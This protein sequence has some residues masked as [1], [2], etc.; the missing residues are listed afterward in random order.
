MPVDTPVFAARKGTVVRKAKN[1]L[2]ILHEDST[3]ATYNHLG[4]IA[5]DIVVGKVISTEDVIGTAGAVDS[6]EAYIQLTVWRPEAP[7]AGSATSAPPNMGFDLVS[8]PLEFCSR[9][10]NECSIL[11]QSQWLSQNKVTEAKKQR[12]PKPGNKSK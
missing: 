10:S 9:S 1:K 8:F 2:D 12:K 6:K 3:I 7:P 4:K 11:T 5:D